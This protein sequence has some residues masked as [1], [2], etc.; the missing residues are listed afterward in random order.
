[1]DIK[2]LVQ[3]GVEWINLAWD[4]ENFRVFFDTVMKLSFP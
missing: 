1:M 2:K 3:K 4:I